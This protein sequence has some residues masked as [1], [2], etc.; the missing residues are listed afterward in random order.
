MEVNA[1]RQRMVVEGVTELSW[2]PVTPCPATATFED[3]E[4]PVINIQLQS[5]CKA[6]A[7]GG[8]SMPAGKACD[9]SDVSFVSMVSASEDEGE[10]VVDMGTQPPSLVQS[11]VPNVVGAGLVGQGCNIKWREKKVKALRFTQFSGLE[12][13]AVK[14]QEGRVE[15][16][17]EE[18]ICR[19][20]SEPP[21]VMEK[22]VI[23]NSQVLSGEGGHYEEGRHYTLVPGWLAKGA[24]GEAAMC[25]DLRSRKS[26]IRKKVQ[27]L[28]KNEVLVPL[29]LKG[30]V[31][32]PEVYG[33]IRRGPDTE[34]FQEFAG[35]SLEKLCNSEWAVHLR[36][37]V[38]GLAFQAFITLYKLHS[39]GIQHLDIKPQ[40]ICVDLS[41]GEPRLK[42]IDFGSSQMA[43]QVSVE[44]LTYEYLSPESCRSL[45]RM[46]QTSTLERLGAGTDVWA[47]TLSLMYCLCGYHVMIK[48]CTG[49]NEYQATT[50]QQ[51]TLQRIDCLRKVGSMTD[52]DVSRLMAP[53]WPEVLRTLFI[54]TLRVNPEHRW[55]ADNAASFLV[56]HLKASA[57]KAQAEDPPAPAVPSVSM[58]GGSVLRLRGQPT[59]TPGEQRLMV[60]HRDQQPL[61]GD[62]TL[63]RVHQGVA[64]TRGP[65][66]HQVPSVSATRAHCVHGK[67]KCSA[68]MAVN[69]SKVIK[70]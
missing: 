49:Q 51:Y 10:E 64:A 21:P 28:S 66:H 50:P 17:D 2:V 37:K 23:C 26:I 30:C 19:L 57:Q 25:H 52:E 67:R 68:E 27:K 22:G 36:D 13:A 44:G 14:R 1:L 34:I 55:T 60:L 54:N 40:N 5:P 35:L 32:I 48:H 70:K 31:G 4:D 41:H 56:L 7:L 6:P 61:Y 65:P 46:S 8:K 33:V 45:C 38:V 9:A 20:L 39:K 3:E 12:V 16:G 29:K 53:Q 62:R 47:T 43:G 59:G 63:Q 42:F 24:Y 15:L 58:T 69:G 11:Q 18:D